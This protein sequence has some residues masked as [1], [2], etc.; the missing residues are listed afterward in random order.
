MN[1]NSNT[2]IITY[3]TILVVVVAAILSFAALKLKTPQENNVKMEKMGDILRSIGKGEDADKVA[4]KFA[5]INEQYKKYIINSYSV[6]TEGNVVEGTDAFNIALNL[7]AE[8]DKPVAERVLPIF[9]SKDDNGD[10]HY[11]IPVWGSGLWGPIWGYIAL[12]SNFDT[13]YG[14]V[15]A[16]K[17][18]TPGLGAEIATPPFQD[19]LKGKTIFDNNKLVAITVLKGAGSS[20]GNPHAVDAIS[21]GTITSRAVENMLKDCLKDY[22]AYFTKMREAQTNTVPAA[23]LVPATPADSTTANNVGH[24]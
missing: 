1:K 19:Q 24:E 2:Y 20:T 16:H 10:I 11:I 7:K 23:E 8:Y 14:A 18:E 9:E 6:N 4:D 3:A 12:D 21:G 13:I 17:S 5:Y 15:F 22:D